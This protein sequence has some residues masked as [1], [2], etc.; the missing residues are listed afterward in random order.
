MFTSG[1]SASER[2]PVTHVPCLEHVAP[3]IML[4]DDGDIL[5]MLHVRGI[6]CEIADADAL[7][8]KHAQLN[9]LLRNIASDRPVRS[10]H[11]V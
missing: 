5:T 4:L 7:N 2:D 6:V 9:T 11:H 3:G 10:D 8:A 1:S